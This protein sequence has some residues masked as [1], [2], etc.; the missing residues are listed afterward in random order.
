MTINVYLR[1]F[2]Y[3]ALLESCD[4]LRL[5]GMCICNDIIFIKDSISGN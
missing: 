2:T 1:H 3:T 5:K 4:G